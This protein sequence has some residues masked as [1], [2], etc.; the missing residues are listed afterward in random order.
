LDDLNTKSSVGHV[1]KLLNLSRNDKGCVPFIRVIV[2]NEEEEEAEAEKTE[3]EKQ[4]R[5]IRDSPLSTM[6][7]LCERRSLD[8]MVSGLLKMEMDVAASITSS[9]STNEEGRKI[10]NTTNNRQQRQK[11]LFELPEKIAYVL[12]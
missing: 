9:L 3:S 12:V 2:L 8:R 6:S 4:K 10:V 11:C 5:S 7:V 1:T